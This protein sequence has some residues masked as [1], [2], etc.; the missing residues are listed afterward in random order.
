[1]ENTNTNV[2]VP[3]TNVPAVPEMKPI[4][5]GKMIGIVAGSVAGGAGLGVGA[6]LG[7]QKFIAWRRRKK[8]EKEKAAE[9]T[10]EKPA[11]EKP[12]EEKPAEETK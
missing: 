10:V 9:K 7:I 8:A 4:S 11:A 3:T 5:Q 12:A 6:T 2:T 1:M